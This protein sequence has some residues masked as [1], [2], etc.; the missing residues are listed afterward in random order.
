MFTGLISDGARPHGGGSIKMGDAR[1]LC[2]DM[3]DALENCE[4]QMTIAG[5]GYV[6]KSLREQLAWFMER[7]DAI[8]WE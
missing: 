6:T 4:M 2:E 5:L 3:I 8:E 1:E 7:M